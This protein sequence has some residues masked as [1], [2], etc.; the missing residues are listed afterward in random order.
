M[1]VAA[2]RNAKKTNNSRKLTD[3]DVIDIRW[4]PH[5]GRLKDL[6]RIAL[7]YGVTEKA[8]R[9]IFSG[10]TYANLP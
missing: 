1:T 10:R 2:K 3:G 8:I 9:D 5:S 6:H 4:A 7:Q